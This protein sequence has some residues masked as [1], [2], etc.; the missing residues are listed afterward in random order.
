MTTS[1]QVQ[2]PRLYCAL[3]T[4]DVPLRTYIGSEVKHSFGPK[5]YSTALVFLLSYIALS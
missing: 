1:A 4:D 5:T 3:P 2:S